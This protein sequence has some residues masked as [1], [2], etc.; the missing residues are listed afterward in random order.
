MSR[1]GGAT[2]LDDPRGKSGIRPGKSPARFGEDAL[3][4]AAIVL[5]SLDQP[6]ASQLLA[7]MDPAAAEAVTHHVAGLERVA[8]EEQHAALEEFYDTALRRLSFTFEDL[9]TLSDH[10]IAAAYSE[11]DSEAWTLA[12]AGA[13]RAVRDKVLRALAPADSARLRRNIER[14]GP[15]RLD[16]SEAAQAEV[17]ERLR[18]LHD[19]GAIDLPAPGETDGKL[20]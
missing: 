10:G 20:V 4:K 18:S 14:L 7:R 9:I 15:F 13:S 3:R 12:L 5:V 2:L 1:T 19:S 16:D 8:P 17:A 6:L 11:A